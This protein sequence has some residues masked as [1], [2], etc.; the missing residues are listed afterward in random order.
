MLDSIEDSTAPAVLQGVSY[1]ELV[2]QACLARNSSV[3]YGGV[4]PIE[5][6]FGRRP[7]DILSLENQSPAQL[8]GSP[9]DVESTA[10]AV[11]SLLRRL[12]VSL[13]SQKMSAA[14][15]PRA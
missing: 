2:K 8:T 11:K 7:R 6:A 12:T 9:A 10:S 4:T 14:T 13:G 1:Q 5:L 3:T 15:L